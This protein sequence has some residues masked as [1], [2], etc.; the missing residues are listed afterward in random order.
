MELVI[1]RKG[2]DL[3]LTAFQVVMPS[4]QNL[5][6]GQKLLIM[7]FIAGLSGDHLSREKSDWMPLTNFRRWVEI[8]SFIAYL[9]R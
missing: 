8:V 3:V 2:E 4:F 9:T 1:V 5:N 7:D 6:N